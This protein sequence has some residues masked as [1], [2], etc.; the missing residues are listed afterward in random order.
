MKKVRP[1]DATA[2]HLLG[3]LLEE[4]VLFRSIETTEEGFARCRALVRDFLTT[5]NEFVE[6]AFA[7]ERDRAKEAED[8]YNEMAPYEAIVVELLKAAPEGMLRDYEPALYPV[9][10]KLHMANMAARARRAAEET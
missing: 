4:T 9:D 8:S 7:T 5:R 3:S 6:A 2:R 1:G 10:K